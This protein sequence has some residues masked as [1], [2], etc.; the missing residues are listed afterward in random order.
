[1]NFQ[2]ARKDFENAVPVS[3]GEYLDGAIET[4]QA[5]LAYALAG[6][7]YADRVVSAVAASDFSEPIHQ[8]V[9]SVI[10]SLR[11]DKRDPYPRLVAEALGDD[12]VADNLTL[13]GYL[14]RLHQALAA[15][16]YGTL[17][18]AIETLRDDARRRALHQVG[19]MLATAALAGRN[20]ISDVAQRAAHEID[21]V[22]ASLR[23]GKARAYDAAKAADIAIQ[24]M[25]G[26]APAWP[27][28]GLDDLDKM[29]GGWPRGQLSVL[30]ARPA[31]GKSAAATCAALK[32]AQRGTATLFFS[33]EMVG[34]QLGARLLTDL[35]FTRDNPIAYEDI[36]HRR[37]VG[38]C[39]RRRLNE[40]R[41]LLRNLP[42]RIEEQRGLTMAD[43]AVRA[44]K[45][46]NEFDRHGMKLDLIIVDHMLLV[47]ASS[48]Y[49]GNRVREVA[50]ISD[51][52]A[53]LAS[54]LDCAMLAL[55]QLNRSVEGRENRRPDLQHLRDSG[56]IEEDASV[57]TF[58][59]RPEY[60]LQKPEDDK[61]LD[62]KRL[63]M[64]NG[65]AWLRANQQYLSEAGYPVHCINRDPAKDQP[66][67]RNLLEY[68]VAKNRNGRTGVV[69]AYC[70]IAANAIRNLGR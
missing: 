20:L 65:T 35:A 51:G 59:Y 48:R 22:L 14:K 31:M 38:E 28:T 60:Y 13:T 19:S 46:A 62:L 63:E 5:V 58:L 40:A 1:M 41:Q 37:I 11:A 18:G 66:G 15:G 25:D 52:L 3:L 24:H 61:E 47:R 26:D 64:L 33:L 67:K 23:T 69:T 12:V 54:E 32:A 16:E 17:E 10:A 44:R 34:E 68:I 2:N 55:C 53:T 9:Y 43:I 42:L 39:I 36:L 49:A 27:T 50:E 7:E 8:Q 70:N 6:G 21:D 30:A 57:V 29:L 45:A 4:E 56:A